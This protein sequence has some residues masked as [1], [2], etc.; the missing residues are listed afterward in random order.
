[1]LERPSAR[2]DGFADWY[3]SFNT[4]NAALN[5]A[6][7]EHALGEG[8]G[9]CLDLGCG[10][11]QYF[12][13]IR[14]TGQVPIGLDLSA[15]QLRYA[16]QRGSCVQADGAA[17]PF[18]DGAFSTVLMLWVSTDVDDFTAVVAEATRVLRRGGLML[19]RGAHPCFIGPHAEYRDD[20]G[21]IIH[22]IYRQAGWHTPQPWWA[23]RDGL[24]NRVGMRQIP[25][26]QLLHTF[27]DAGL[28]IE[29]VVEPELRHPVPFVLELS[30]RRPR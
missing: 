21:R 16:R 28:F 20:G 5:R 14:A 25:L 3:E 12:D 13:A 1:M 27:L 29:K 15:D 18:A 30:L 24:R 19:F 7:L 6:D 17:L 4:P 26:A 9:L 8:E 2:Y 23:Q 10:T 22:P 11:G